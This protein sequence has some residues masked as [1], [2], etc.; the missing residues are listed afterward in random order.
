MIRIMVA[1]QQA[2]S[3]YL[4]KIIGASQRVIQSFYFF[5]L[6]T[7]LENSLLILDGSLGITSCSV[8]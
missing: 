5:F 2:R 4:N 1:Q 6:E 8:S 3:S 7:N